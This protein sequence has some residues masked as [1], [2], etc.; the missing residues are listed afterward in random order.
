MVL[1]TICSK[2]PSVFN[3]PI[4]IQTA[5]ASAQLDVTPELWPK[6]RFRPS[7][8]LNKFTAVLY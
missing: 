5:T 4:A 2:E 6:P 3:K 8:K 1:S 7:K